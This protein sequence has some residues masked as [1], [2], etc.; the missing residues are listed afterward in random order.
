MIERL[1]NNVLDV[2]GVEGMSI[3]DSEGA[4]LSN[5]LPDYYPE[6][7]IT[8]TL[9][10]IVSLYQVVD[11]SFLP[12]DDYLLKY[13]GKWILLRRNKDTYTLILTEP[14]VNQVT[15][16]MVTN[17]LLKNIKLDVLRA[18]ATPVE[19]ESLPPPTHTRGTTRTPFPNGTAQRHPPP[20]QTPRKRSFRG[21]SY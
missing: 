15:L 2:P 18:S 3:F 13:E 5:R 14:D 1:I 17:L 20:A 10:R 16:R 12:C 4:L 19:T 11:D 7:I 6:E 8:E 21:S 9:S